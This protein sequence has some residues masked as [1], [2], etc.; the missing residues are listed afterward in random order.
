MMISWVKEAFKNRIMELGEE[1]LDELSEQRS[2][3]KVDAITEMVAYP[4][5]IFDNDYVNGISETVSCVTCFKNSNL[6][7]ML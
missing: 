6:M 3:A 4:D 7:P 5:Q 1:W 2:I